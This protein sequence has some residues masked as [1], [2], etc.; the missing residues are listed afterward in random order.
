[1]S[2]LYPFADKRS[3]CNWRFFSVTQCCIRL[4]EPFRQ[5]LFYAEL[6]YQRITKSV[7]KIFFTKMEIYA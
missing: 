2:D 5:G 6:S 4:L 1:M 3:F 7:I